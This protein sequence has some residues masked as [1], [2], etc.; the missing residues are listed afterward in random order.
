MITPYSFDEDWD[1]ENCSFVVDGLDKEGRCHGCGQV[2]LLPYRA[3]Y[4]R[5]CIVHQEAGMDIAFRDD[6]F[7]SY[8]EG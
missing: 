7:D 4:C 5:T 3:N 8:I 2:R 6:D 1:P